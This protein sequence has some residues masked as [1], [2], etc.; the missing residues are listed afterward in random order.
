MVPFWYLESDWM[1]NFDWSGL[2]RESQ[3]ISTKSRTSSIS[4]SFI[5][6]WSL[7]I[8]LVSKLRSRFQV[9]PLIKLRCSTYMCIL[10][11][12]VLS[13]LLKENSIEYLIKIMQIF[14]F[15]N[16]TDIFH[17]ADLRLIFTNFRIDIILRYSF[18]LK[19]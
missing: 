10:L 19:Q 17:S 11:W 2:F 3:R 8:F 5:P 13:I 4:I 9:F 18:L 1:S 7:A 15:K 16:F 6:V 12:I 14:W